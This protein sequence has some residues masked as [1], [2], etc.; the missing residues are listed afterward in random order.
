M[1]LNVW[2]PTGQEKFAGLVPL[3]SREADALVYVYDV[4]NDMLFDHLK[5]WIGIV[6]GTT[7]A[8]PGFVV[9]NKIDA[10]DEQTDAAREVAFATEN[11]FV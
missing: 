7:A 6:E 10:L 11:G 5:M 2:E 9:G 1:P 3:Y 8:V 4:T